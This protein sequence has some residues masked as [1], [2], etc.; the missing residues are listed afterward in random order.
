VPRGTRVRVSLSEAASVRFVVR[1]RSDGRRIGSFVR[2][3]ASGQSSVF[4][5]GRLRVR[6][7][8]LSLAPGRY[9]LTLVATDPSGN[10]SAARRLS[11]RVLR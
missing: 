7:R 10:R 1:R 8:A 2:P 6:G 9:R 3:A 5:S 11:F 4:F